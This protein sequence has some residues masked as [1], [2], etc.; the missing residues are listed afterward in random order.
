MRTL[1]DT[2]V[3]VDYFRGTGNTTLLDRLMDENSLLVNDLILAELVPF[4][5]VQNYQRLIRLLTAIEQLPLQID[6]AEIIEVQYRCVKNGLN[7]LGIPDLL[8][9]QNAVQ[10][11]VALYTH[12][13]HF[14]KMRTAVPLD[15]VVLPIHCGE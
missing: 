7:G 3:W 9:A 1:V 11:Q 10:H 12:D 6:W 8:I 2:S 15:L 5:K 14:E 4:L 13:R